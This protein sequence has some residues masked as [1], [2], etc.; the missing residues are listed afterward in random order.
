[1]LNALFPNQKDNSKLLYHM[2]LTN[3]APTN[4]KQQHI[5]NTY[6][7]QQDCPMIYFPS[8]R[9]VGNVFSNGLIFHYFQNVAPIVIVIF[10]FFLL[11]LL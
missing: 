3:P 6:F 9:T 8:S 7:F 1:M 10:L 4:Y 2:I 11:I 5:G